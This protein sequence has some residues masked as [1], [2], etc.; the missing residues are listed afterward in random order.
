MRT[1]RAPRALSTVVQQ[2]AYGTKSRAQAHSEWE[3]DAKVD[4]VSS[5]PVACIE[6]FVILG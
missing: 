4:D 6:I 3:N 2:I 5:G 1:C